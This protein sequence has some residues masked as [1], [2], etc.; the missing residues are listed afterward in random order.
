M[1]CWE[2]MKDIY[3][4]VSQAFLKKAGFCQCTIF[5]LRKK[6]VAVRPWLDIKAVFLFRQAVQNMVNL[7]NFRHF[8]A[9]FCFSQRGGGQMMVSSSTKHDRFHEHFFGIL[10]TLRTSLPAMSPKSH[11]TCWKGVY[12]YKYE[13]KRALWS[14]HVANHCEMNNL[15]HSWALFLTDTID[16]WRACLINRGRQ[17]GEVK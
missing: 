14:A 9:T 13:G 12:L 17:R 5:F 16:K 15:L 4:Q 8:A 2:G 1:L 10:Q 3:L 6:N 7:K 11:E